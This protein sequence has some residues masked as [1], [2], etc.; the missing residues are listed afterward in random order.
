M[1][2]KQKLLT[3]FSLALLSAIIISAALY[4]HKALVPSSALPTSAKLVGSYDYRVTIQNNALVEVTESPS[5]FYTTDNSIYFVYRKDGVFTAQQYIITSADPTNHAIYL[6]DHTGLTFL[7]SPKL[8]GECL[9]F[10][11]SMGGVRVL[12][13]KQN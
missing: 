11:D 5:H 7:I 1:S 12:Y 8:K 2:T 13:K 4:G 6:K 9:L 10:A 3:Y